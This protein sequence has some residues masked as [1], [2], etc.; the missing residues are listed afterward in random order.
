[1]RTLYYDDK[2]PVCRGFASML[3]RKLPSNAIA[4]EPVSDGAKEFRYTT[5]GGVTLSGDVAL[6]ALLNDFPSVKEFFW[7]LPDSLKMPA[8]KSVVAAAG[9][10]RQ[11]INIVRP[12]GSCG[13]R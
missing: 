4:F 12:C 3:R 13:K 8:V 7:M 1:M 2:C 11:A 5:D 10:L 6:D 9:V